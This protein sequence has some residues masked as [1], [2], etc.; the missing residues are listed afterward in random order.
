MCEHL[1]VHLGIPSVRN[2]LCRPLPSTNAAW[3]LRAQGMTATDLATMTR[4]QPRSA[5]GLRCSTATA[6]AAMQE[7]FSPTILF[8]TTGWTC[9]LWI[10]PMNSCG[11]GGTASPSTLLILAGTRRLHCEM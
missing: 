9:F 8:T 6:E 4:S 1:R 3:Y 10:Q 5:T 2:E 11:K 7:N